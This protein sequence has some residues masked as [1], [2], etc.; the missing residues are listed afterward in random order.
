[1]K[2]A[3]KTPPEIVV[4]YYCRVLRDGMYYVADRTDLYVISERDVGDFLAGPFAL[5]FQNQ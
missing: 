2:A 4:N 5:S 1:M 3:E